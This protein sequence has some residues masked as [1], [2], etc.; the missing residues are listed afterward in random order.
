MNLIVGAT[1]LLGGR[2][3]EKLGDAEKAVRALVRASAD[4][5]KQKRFLHDGIDIFEGDL[6]DPASL[7]AACEGVTTVISTASASLSRQAG[8]SIQTV[9]EEGQ[10]SLIRAAEAAGVRHFI[11]VSFP[12]MPEDFPLQRAKRKAE[13]LLEKS[14][15]RYTIVQPTF[16]M[17]VWLSPALG[18]DIANAKAKIYG[19]GQNSISW[20]SYP[21]VA[22]FVAASVDNP[23]AHNKT[24]P[25]GGPDSVSPLDVVSLCEQI[26]GRSFSVEHVPEEVLR[27]QKAVA[28]D[29]LS[30]S[31]AGFMLGY[32]A[33]QHI[34]MKATLEILPVPLTS[35][36]NYV[37]GVLGSAAAAPSV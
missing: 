3:C 18:F 35:L 13:Q 29:P 8:D 4:P 37:R 12:P 14:G 33:G 15:M 9:D 1:G 30:E 36:R 11:L 17:E 19:S 20:I 6:K 32:A 28:A 23:A 16:F 5:L 27:Q 24:V 25:L 34:D 7:D 26:G 10:L 31:F 21:D 22:G 2:I